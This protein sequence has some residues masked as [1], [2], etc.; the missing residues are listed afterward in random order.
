MATSLLFVTDDSPARWTLVS[1]LKSRFA[2]TS[3]VQSL[4]VENTTFNMFLAFEALEDVASER[5][6]DYQS[7]RRL[8]TVENVDIGGLCRHVDAVVV[9]G[10]V[11]TRWV[12]G[13]C[14]RPTLILFTSRHQVD[15]LLRE[16]EPGL[17][18][19]I[20]W[21]ADPLLNLAMIRQVLQPSS[22]VGVL[23]SEHSQTWLRPLTPM[24]ETLR[25][26]LDIIPAQDDE[27]AVRLLRQRIDTLDAVL[28]I[29][30][31]HL[32]NGWSLKPILLMTARKFIP[33]FGGTTEQYVKAGTTAAIVADSRQLMGQIKTFLRQLM[34]GETPAPDYPTA[35][36]VAINSVV[37]QAL[38]IDMEKLSNAHA[39]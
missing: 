7:P 12:R 6:R 24:A 3:A 14:Q 4:S 27:D 17:I 35:T 21:E 31:E 16:T 15:D 30:D 18:S 19:A 2:E 1:Q 20:Y 39:H 38:S 25:L 32:I 33:V 11:A 34:K 8:M 22:T 5:E 13:V 28:L 26:K 29:P 37:A 36:R 23:V 9:S 10:L